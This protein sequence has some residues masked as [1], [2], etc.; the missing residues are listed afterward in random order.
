M[1]RAK[2]K[3][4]LNRYADGKC[5]PSEAALVEAWIK[6]EEYLSNWS[7]QDEQEAII[8]KNR[9][10]G[11]LKDKTRVK[12]HP[13]I[14]RTPWAWAATALLFLL[15]FGY[16]YL[17]QAKPSQYVQLAI[18]KP[19]Q[20]AVA[21]GTLSATLTTGDGKT[22]DLSTLSDGILANDLALI[23]KE[24]DGQL[25]YDVKQQKQLTKVDTN[26][27]SV[28]IGGNYQ[29]I[30]PDGSKVWLNAASKLKYPV[31]FTENTRK[32]YLEGEA[33]FEVAHNTKQPFVVVSR[34]TETRVTG[35]SFNI[36][37]Y[38][39]DDLE[40]TSLLEGEVIVKAG[41]Q[42][43]QLKP[44]QQSQFEGTNSLK[45]LTADME[46]ALAWKGG[47]FIFDNQDISTSLKEIARWYN[48][49]IFIQRKGKSSKNIGGTFSK[50]RN[51]DE[52]LQSLVKLHVLT[53]SREG[54]R[55]MVVI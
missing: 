23:T 44:S 35:T 34:R 13:R 32:V 7:W 47:Y 22:I 29:V 37:A 6:E 5:S 49:D 52:L 12:T 55:I 28:P 33:Y 20:E 36:S 43:V 4:L 18:N 24:V 25:R 40:L 9:I 1:T 26:T 21:P 54:R 51:L 53:Y 46:A 30:L 42:E 17:Q 41:Q 15:G 10:L 2:A 3:D 39:E 48:V 14:Y 16:I 31:A 50:K 8:T 19:A 38:P 27:L 11:K 45:V